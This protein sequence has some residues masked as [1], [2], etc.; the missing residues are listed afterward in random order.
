M[1]FWMWEMAIPESVQPEFG[2]VAAMIKRW[3]EE[4]FAYF[5][6]PHLTNAFTENRNGLVKM[7]NRAGRGYS[8][9]AIRAK[10]LL[11]K[12][13]GRMAECPTCEAIL[14]VESFKTKAGAGL[15]DDLAVCGTCHVRFNTQ[16]IFRRRAEKHASS[17]HQT[18]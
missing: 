16:P 7:V 5:D 8:F 17:T 4:V 13:L 6:Y 11:A 18:G 3:R 1:E 2:K 15:P 14:P 12:P 10:A 9:K